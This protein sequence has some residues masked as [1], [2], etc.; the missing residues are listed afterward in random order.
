MAVYGN[1]SGHKAQ[2]IVVSSG[3]V[4]ELLRPDEAGHMQ[5]VLTTNVFGA[6]PLGLRWTCSGLC[7]AQGSG[8]AARA[9]AIRAIAPFR[10]PGDKT[11]DYLIIGSDSGKVTIVSYDQAGPRLAHVDGS[12]TGACLCHTVL[13]PVACP[14][15][16]H[17]P[18]LGGLIPPGPRTPDPGP[19]PLTA[20]LCRSATRSS[21]CTRR[22]LA[23]A[24]AGASCPARW[25][26]STP[27]AAPA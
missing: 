16:L 14:M 27:R 18:E 13:Q 24:A 19:E 1:F 7:L 10:L 12:A 4:L 2:E 22:R 11:L 6:P 20:R 17:S 26:P 21:A 9:G 5:T 3:S 25:W 15:A 8:R 23:R